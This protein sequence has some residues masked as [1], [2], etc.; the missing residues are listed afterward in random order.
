MAEVTN[1]LIYEVLKRLQ[2]DVG[3]LKDGQREMNGQLQA[4]REHM[5]ATQ[6]DI[7]NVY[8]RLVGFELRLERIERR[9]DLIQEP[10]E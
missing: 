6:K 3:L 1:E 5:L 4:M 7:T 10:A 8:D 2:N 9:L